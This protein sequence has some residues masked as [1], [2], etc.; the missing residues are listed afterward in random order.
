M[1]CPICHHCGQASK[2]VTG[3]EVYPHR[4]DLSTLHFYMC[5]PCGAWVGTHKGTKTPLGTPA[6]AALRVARSRAHAAF[7]PIWR[8][9]KKSR[10]VA[11]AWLSQQL[12][13]S[14][15]DTHIGMFSADQ[16]EATVAAAERL[17][18]KHE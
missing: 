1:S 2:L 16:C 15:S 9:G 12:G 5:T 13:L 17:E 11:Y 8:D 7:D 10:S 4:P 18:N 3:M 14:K 6:N